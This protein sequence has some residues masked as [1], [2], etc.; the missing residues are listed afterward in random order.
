MEA[1]LILFI[2]SVQFAVLYF[3]VGYLVKLNDRIVFFNEKVVLLTP[4]IESSIKKTREIL[5]KIN[6]RFLAFWDT[7][8]KFGILRNILIVKSLIVAIVV[9]KSRKNILSFFSLYNVV[10]AFRKMLMEMK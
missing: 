2:L 9:F 10:N 5:I 8:S 4:Q 7:N 6:K 1:I 3:G